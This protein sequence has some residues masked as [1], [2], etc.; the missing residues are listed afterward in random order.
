[1]TSKSKNN[2]IN[3]NRLHTRLLVQCMVDAQQSRLTNYITML[4]A[5]D[6]YI[7]VMIF[8]IATVLDREIK[9]LAKRTNKKINDHSHSLV[10]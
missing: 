8:S 1:M 3:I 9:N 7:R 4:N 10:Q 2:K 5:P 6:S